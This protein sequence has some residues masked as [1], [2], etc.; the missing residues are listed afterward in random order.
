MKKIQRWFQ[1]LISR[2]LGRVYYFIGASYRYFGNTYG[3]ISEYEHA[4][5]AL[6]RAVTWNPNFAQAYMERGILF[7]REMDHPRRAIIDLTTAYTLDPS[8]AEARF[9]RGIAHQQLREYD[10]AM[11]DFKAYL[12]TGDHPYWREYAE[13][14]V[15]ELQE[16]V[17]ISDSAD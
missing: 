17:Y 7:W 15:R 5:D 4:I 9:N 1:D 2:A 12:A 8:L 6:S 3:L 10:Q 13:N 16:W 14:M 11:A